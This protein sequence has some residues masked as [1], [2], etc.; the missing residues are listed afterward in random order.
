MKIPRLNVDEGTFSEELFKRF[1]FRY[2]IEQSK[3]LLRSL[4]RPVDNYAIR[5]SIHKIS[6]EHLIEKLEKDD[7]KCSMH[8][9]LLEIIVVKTK[10]PKLVQFYQ[11]QPRITLDKY[12]AE[13]VLV[14]ANLFGVGIKKIPKFSEKESVSLITEKDQIV[15]NGITKRSS[16]NPRRPGI[17]VIN[18]ESFFNVPSLRELNL[19]KTGEAYSQSIPATYVAHVLDPQK[20]EKIIDLCAAPGGKTTSAAILSN[21]KANIIA[22]DRS[23]RRLEKLRKTIKYQKLSNIKIINADCISYAKTHTLKADKVIVD[24]SCTAIGVRP[25]VYENTKEKEIIDSAKYQKSF[26]WLASN[27]VRKKGVVTYSTCTLSP[28]ENEKNIAYAVNELGLKLVEPELLLGEKG[29]DTNDGL[30]LE[31]MRR[32]YPHINN[33]PGFFVAKL[34]KT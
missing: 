27:I 30:N 19:L 20:N 4:S 25:K 2:G 6:R 5:A 23:K 17:A 13:S 22:F 12:A 28:E 14:G 3:K 31:Y 18:Q 15:A 11:H 24:P 33:T 34:L 16:K 32:F 8:K 9:E 1:K 10:G 7:W 21:N 29:E 26:L